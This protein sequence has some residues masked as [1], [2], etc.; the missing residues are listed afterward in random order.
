MV[1]WNNKI[2]STN[3]ILERAIRVEVYIEIK[4]ENHIIAIEITALTLKTRRDFLFV[5]LSLPP[6]SLSVFLFCMKN[7]FGRSIPRQEFGQKRRGNKK[8]K[9]V[10]M[11]PLPLK[12]RLFHRYLRG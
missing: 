3:E 1:Y 2:G 6:P 5:L 7:H 10:N 12:V 8:R 11:K 9:R 4:M